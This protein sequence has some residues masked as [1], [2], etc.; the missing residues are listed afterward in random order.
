MFD[1]NINENGELIYNSNIQDVDYIKDD[2]LIK[3]ISTNRIKSVVGDWFN[4]RIG[5]N[6]EEFLGLPN[7]PSN[8]NEIINRIE[9][10]LV[11]DDFLLESDLYIIPKID[12]TNLSLKVFIKGKYSSSPILID[13]YIDIVSG[14]KIINDAN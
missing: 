4:S 3:Q 11:Y 5:A 6:L 7:T 13:V 2:D 1:F 12:K 8:T 10:A 14:V 9:N